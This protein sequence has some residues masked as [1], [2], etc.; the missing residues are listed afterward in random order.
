MKEK[1]APCIDLGQPL[2]VIGVQAEFGL[3]REILAVLLLHVCIRL[4]DSGLRSL[5]VACVL[6][7]LLMF[8]VAERRIR[9]HVVWI[10]GV[11]LDSRCTPIE[12]R[13]E[14]GVLGLNVATQRDRRPDR[15]NQQ[16]AHWMAIES[17]ESFGLGFTY[18]VH[19]IHICLVFI[20]LFLFSIFSKHG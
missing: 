17:L 14:V 13:W 1:W 11:A 16:K 18:K 20:F 5:L 6:R 7:K 19:C 2:C 15:C 9:Q 10:R 12:R 3:D 4:M 8:V